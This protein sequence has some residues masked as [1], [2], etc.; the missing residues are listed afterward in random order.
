MLGPGEALQAANAMP[1]MMRTAHS[2]HVSFTALPQL[3]RHS[4]QHAFAM[5]GIVDQILPMSLAYLVHKPLECGLLTT[6]SH[7]IKMRC[8][9]P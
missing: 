2:D 3:S 8:F 6:K 7:R 4:C 1:C 5:I 9:P